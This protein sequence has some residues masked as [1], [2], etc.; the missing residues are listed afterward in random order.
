V[1]GAQTECGVRVLDGEI[2]LLPAL[3]PTTTLAHFE[4]WVRVF[5]PACARR[6]QSMAQ[7][8]LAVY[9]P[10]AV[11]YT[12]ATTDSLATQPVQICTAHAPGT[13]RPRALSPLGYVAS[14]VPRARP[15]NVGP[16]DSA[17]AVLHRGMRLGARSAG[18]LMV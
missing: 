17:A 3:S 14:A 1:E 18:R 2:C 6:A 16:G 7:Y 9:P 12:P 13:A 8:T 15:Y 10:A 11:G 5:L 4:I